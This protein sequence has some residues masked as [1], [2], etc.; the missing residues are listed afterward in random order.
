MAL[1]KIKNVKNNQVRL[2]YNGIFKN[3]FKHSR[4]LYLFCNN[5]EIIGVES[6][7]L[8]HLINPHINHYIKKIHGLFSV[9]YIFDYNVLRNIAVYKENNSIK[10]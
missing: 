3:G 10:K 1:R 6:K 2:R 4:D 9:Y 5:N 7:D 8:I